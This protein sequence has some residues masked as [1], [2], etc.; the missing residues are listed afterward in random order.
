MPDIVDTHCH[1]DFTDFDAD[2]DAVLKACTENQVSDIVVP[3]VSQPTWHNT[4]SLCQRHKQ[5]HL[6]LGLHPIFIDQHQPQ[7]LNE[8]DQLV[9]DTNPVAIGEIGLD[10]YLKQLDQEKQ[11]LFFS[12]QLIIAKHHSLPVIIHNRKAHDQCINL[13]REISVVGG[14]IHNFNGSI[15][16]AHKYIELGFKLGF[17]G[18]LTFQRSRVIRQ[19]AKQIPIEAIV[20]ETDAPDLT[21][22]AHRGT[23]NSPEY[24]PHVLAALAEVK[25][26]SKTQV[27][28]ETSRNA[29]SVLNLQTR[30][31]TP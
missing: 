24:L 25:E 4:I 31:Q 13:L 11:T 7:H 12:K 28:L 18:M 20:L 22:E 3:A 30:S 23:R 9:A 2:R 14:I 10:F 27:A 15:Q 16:H 26:L 5:L 21:V 29:K 1:L 17:G 19:L 6:A 8:L